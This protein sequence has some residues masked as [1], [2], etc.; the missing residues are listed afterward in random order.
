VV[1]VKA[2]A[3][4]SLTI[5][6]LPAGTYGIKYTTSREYDVDLPDV[7][8]GPGQDVHASMPDPG[9]ITVYAKGTPAPVAPAQVVVRGPVWGLSGVP[10]SF[11]AA[12]SPVNATL[13]ITYAWQ[14]SD[15]SPVTHTGG[16]SDTITFT[17]EVTGTQTVTVTATNTHGTVTGTY[18]FPT[19]EG[20]RLFF[21]LILRD[22]F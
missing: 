22:F 11:T 10:H 15:Q 8:V 13:P 18:L 1:V 19:R 21:P 14:A 2:D 17:W 9:V 7:T 6:G 20:L 4:G 3:A 12:V 5:Q 16:L